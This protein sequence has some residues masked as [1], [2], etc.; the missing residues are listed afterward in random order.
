M[1]PVV[2]ARSA[3]PFGTIHSAAVQFMLMVCVI[4]LSVGALSGRNQSP[5]FKSLCRS[6]A[7][8]YCAGTVPVLRKSGS[9]QMISIS[10][11]ELAGSQTG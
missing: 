6:S 2:V 8:P 4:I 1:A 11:S 10:V 9:S 7:A 3:A 5:C